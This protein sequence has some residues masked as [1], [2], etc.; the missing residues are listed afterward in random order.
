VVYHQSLRRY[1]KKTTG[2]TTNI[3]TIILKRSL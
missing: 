2:R 3:Y 1:R